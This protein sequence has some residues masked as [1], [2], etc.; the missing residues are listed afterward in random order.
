MI[1]ARPRLRRARAAA[2]L[3]GMCL[4]TAALADNAME[5]IVVRA[6]AM[7]KTV[8]GRTTIGAPIEEVTLI[9]RVSYADLDLATH[10]GA[11]ALKRRV[12]ET[13]RLAC[14][15]LDKLYPLEEKQEPACIQD[16]LHGAQS[17]IDEAIASAEHQAKG[18]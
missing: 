3:A 14:E 4:A 5:T 13:A 15:Q 7:T 17:Q 16:A 18:E 11:M 9:H 12:R 6:E 1:N 2:L 10:S 8:V